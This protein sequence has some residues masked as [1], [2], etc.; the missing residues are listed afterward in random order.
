[1]PVTQFFE[2][3]FVFFRITYHFSPKFIEELLKNMIIYI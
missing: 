3:L 1:M 2:G